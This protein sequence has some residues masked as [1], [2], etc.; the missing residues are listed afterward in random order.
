MFKFMDFLLRFC[1]VLFGLLSSDD[2]RRLNFETSARFSF[3][4]PVFDRDV[5]VQ[6]IWL[7]TQR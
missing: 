3:C 6:L 2:H 5:R 4:M 7:F 1:S